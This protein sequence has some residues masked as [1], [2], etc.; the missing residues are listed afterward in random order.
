MHLHGLPIDI[1]LKRNQHIAS[2]EKTTQDKSLPLD[3]IAVVLKLNF[4][5]YT[6]DQVWNN[7]KTDL[8]ARIY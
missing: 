2:I 4:H 5:T 1:Q 7:D 3:G 6:S 8:G